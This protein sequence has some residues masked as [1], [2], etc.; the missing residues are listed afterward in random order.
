MLVLEMDMVCKFNSNV[1]SYNDRNVSF[2][3]VIFSKDGSSGFR[4]K[5]NNVPAS[6]FYDSRS[7]K[8]S[9]SN[10]GRFFVLN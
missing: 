2:K 5:S 8:G 9:I 6:L 4:Y 7:S 1:T 3:I 10:Y